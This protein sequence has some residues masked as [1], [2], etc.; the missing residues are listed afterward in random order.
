[1]ITGCTFEKCKHNHSCQDDNL[2]F[3]VKACWNMYWC[4]RQ[5]SLLLLFGI[6]KKPP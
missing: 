5:E 4:L 2:A 6:W 3:T 1:M